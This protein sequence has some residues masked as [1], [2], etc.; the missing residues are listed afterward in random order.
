MELQLGTGLISA[1][2]QLD[3]IA[4]AEQELLDATAPPPQAIGGM[5]ITQ[6]PGIAYFLEQGVL[7]AHARSVNPDLR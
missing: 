5:E 1:R 6:Q 2:G 7:Q 3:P 4:I